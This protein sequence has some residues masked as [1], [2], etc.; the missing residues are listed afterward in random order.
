MAETHRQRLTVYAVSRGHLDELMRRL[1]ETVR[2]YQDEYAPVSV[3]SD[4][5][6]VETSGQSTEEQGHG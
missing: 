6:V 2:E 3:A 4:V 5:S 1:Q